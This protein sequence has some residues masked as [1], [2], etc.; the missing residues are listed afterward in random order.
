M[1]FYFLGTFC[2]PLYKINNDFNDCQD[3][4]DENVTILEINKKDDIQ[5]NFYSSNSN[6]DLLWICDKKLQNASK[7]C[8]GEC[9]IHWKL[10]LSTMF[11]K[12]KCALM[13]TIVVFLVV[14]Q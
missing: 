7:P 10:C 8:N 5:Y 11:Q 9:K 1:V 13:K 3:G 12:K 14:L 6:A 4:S 2:V